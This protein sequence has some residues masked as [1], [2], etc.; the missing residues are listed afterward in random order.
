ML[1]GWYLR[2]LNG[3][4]PVRDGPLDTA[5][6]RMGDP[7]VRPPM[8][9]H[10]RFHTFED[11][12]AD[13][14]EAQPALID[15]VRLC[16]RWKRGFEKRRTLDNNRVGYELGVWIDRAT[17]TWFTRDSTGGLVRRQIELRDTGLS[18]DWKRY[19]L[20]T[21]ITLEREVLEQGAQ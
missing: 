6:V 13:S 12:C 10:I 7:N 14:G 18:D 20:V 3:L 15:A 8:S 2:R 1:L 21:Q 5:G 9:Y 4:S 19:T 11:Q 17:L 16:K